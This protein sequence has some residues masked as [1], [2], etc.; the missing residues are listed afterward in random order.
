MPR[1]ETSSESLPS[2]LSTFT[3]LFSTQSLQPRR[4]I[5]RSLLLRSVRL[6]VVK[7]GG[8][9]DDQERLEGFSRGTLPLRVRPA[10]VLLNV[11]CLV[12]LGI[13]GFHPRGQTYVPINDKILHFICFLFVS[14]NA[15]GRDDFFIL[16]CSTFFVRQLGSFTSSGT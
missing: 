9:W 13:L 8:A 4:E 11:L 10:F 3:S 1:L 12:C 6:R 5:A 15:M 7:E 2:Y 16:A 14:A